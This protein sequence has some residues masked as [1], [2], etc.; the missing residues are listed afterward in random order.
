MRSSS[1][2]LPA[3]DTPWEL[4]ENSGSSRKTSWLTFGE[5]SKGHTALNWCHF[6]GGQVP[7]QEWFCSSGGKGDFFQ[8]F[9]IFGVLPSRAIPAPEGLFL[10]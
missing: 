10:I 8:W 7:P 5:A 2:F 1:S 9:R 4:Q 3:P 6:A